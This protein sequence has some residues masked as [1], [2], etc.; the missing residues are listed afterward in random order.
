MFLLLLL[1]TLLHAQE[2]ADSTYCFRFVAGKD[3]FYSP[4]KGNDREL[5]R[6]QAAI[7]SNRAAIENGRVYLYV[8]SYGTDGNAG[9]PAAKMARIRRNRVKSELITRAGVK[10]I[11]FV[12]D[13]SFAGIYKGKEGE[14]RNVVVVLLPAPATATA[15]QPETL[16]ETTVTEEPR[17]EQTATQETEARTEPAGAEPIDGA[18]SP[19]RFALRANL[20]RWVT[21]TPD[22]GIEWRI[23]R[24]VGILVNGSYTS[25]SWDGKNRHY[26][27]WE[28][29]PEVRWYPGEKMDWYVGA[30]YKVG[31]FN[32]KLSGTGRQ[33]DLMGGGVTGG[34][35]LKLNN[36][37]SMDFSL[38]LGHVRAD[39]DKYTVIN[40]VRVRQGNETKHWFGP[41]QAG[42][43]LVWDILNFNRRR[44]INES[45]I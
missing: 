28:V 12:T 14:L 15:E 4:W 44:Y 42:V 31:S 13:K 35:L 20:L 9:Q 32:Y 18:S 37:L 19:Y 33:G 10:E 45:G 6:L 1:P 21:L 36:S 38:G 39:Y 26:A 24:H 34:Y 29:N 25:W 2:Q 30:M 5:E 8:T 41:V 3:M 23:N 27:L 16:E 40:G 11:H 43:T 7:E 22:L 17:Q